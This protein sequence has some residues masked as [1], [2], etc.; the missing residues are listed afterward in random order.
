MY[1]QFKL[2]LQ[3]IGYVAAILCF[4]IHPCVSFLC[5]VFDECKLL[6]HNVY[7][8]LCLIASLQIWRGLWMFFNIITCMVKFFSIFYS[9]FISF[10]QSF[11]SWQHGVD[12][13]SLRRINT[14]TDT[15][16][17]FKLIIV[18]IDINR[19]WA[20]WVSAWLH[21]ESS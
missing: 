5:D 6:Y 8:V 15:H 16:G 1:T 21:I 13:A 18:R 14:A 10:L 19:W 12:I 9:I 4:I 17:L 2:F 20:S 7:V 11:Y 3:F